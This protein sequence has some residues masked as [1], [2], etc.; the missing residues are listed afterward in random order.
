MASIRKELFLAAGSE[1]V[2][3]ALRDFGAVHA[4][5]A[6]GF[7]TATTM[8]GETIRVVTFFNGTSARETLVSCD[9]AS[10]RLVYAIIGGRAEHYSA[11]AQVFDD[12]PG[13]SRFVWIVDV[14]PDAIAPYIDD[15]MT[16]GAAVMKATL[17]QPPAAS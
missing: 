1:Y 3:S 14:L 16:R 10:R 2:W 8:A 12:G 5:L 4:R 17:D 13:R 15:M 7:V 11:S 9:E 6:P